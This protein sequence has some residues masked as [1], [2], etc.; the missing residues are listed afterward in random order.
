VYGALMKQG[1][2]L[3]PMAGEF[4]FPFIFIRWPSAYFSPLYCSIWGSHT[5]SYISKTLRVY[6]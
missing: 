3:M 4:M 2:T 5:Q 6:L 1:S